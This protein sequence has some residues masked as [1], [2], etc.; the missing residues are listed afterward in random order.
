MQTTIFLLART[1]STRLPKKALLKIDG[2]P[3]IKILIDRIKRD[4]DNKKIIVCTT[5][6]KSDDYLT[7][8]LEKKKI[9]VFRGSNKDVLMRLYCAANEYRVSEFVVVEADD[10]F[11]EPK[12]IDQTRKKLKEGNFEYICWENTPFGT[13]PTGIKTKKLELLIS[14]KKTVNTDTGWGQIIKKSGL[15]TICSLKPNSKRLRRPDI[16]LSVDYVEDF[17]LIKKLYQNLPIRFSLSDIIDM[18]DKNPQW[19]KINEKAIKKYEKNFLTKKASIE[20][21]DKV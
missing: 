20:W 5:K 12:F 1:S 14:R 2:K 9:K 6:L 3:L 8:Y 16:R 21:R 18:L 10:I 4:V 7:E 19:V 13:T 17:N 15:F 11:C